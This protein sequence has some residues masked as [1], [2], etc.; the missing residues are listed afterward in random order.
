MN[1]DKRVP[2]QRILYATDPPRD[3]A[4][5]VLAQPTGVAL[6]T[7][8]TSVIVMTLLLVTAVSVM[9]GLAVS[10]P[11]CVAFKEQQS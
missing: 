10:H 1:H 2:R 6:P 8:S 3:S 4:R 9:G 11:L 5:V 7:F